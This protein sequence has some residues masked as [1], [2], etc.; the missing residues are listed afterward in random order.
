VCNIP[1]AEIESANLVPESHSKVLER[2]EDLVMPQAMINVVVN[3]IL[4]HHME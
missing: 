3:N 1:L 2:L 4:M